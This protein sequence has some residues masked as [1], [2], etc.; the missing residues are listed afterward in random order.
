MAPVGLA[1]YPCDAG[2]LTTDQRGPV[3]LIAR[4]IQVAYDA[5]VARRAALTESQLRAEGIG[6]SEHVTLQRIGRRLRLLLYGGGGCG[7]TRIINYVLAKSF[8][9][10]YGDKGVVPTAFFQRSL[11][12]YQR[13]D[14][15]HS[16]KNPRWPV[17]HHGSIAR[18]G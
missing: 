4:D 17:P 15:P 5:E 13:Q 16:Y 11:P 10:F 7:K 12:S 3:A 14:G 8:R 1:K 18:S 9:R 2:E 6:A